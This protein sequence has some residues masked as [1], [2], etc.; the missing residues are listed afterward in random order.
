MP[1]PV[2]RHGNAA[3]LINSS[4]LL[5]ATYSDVYVGKEREKSASEMIIIY[6]FFPFTYIFQLTIFF[7]IKL[8]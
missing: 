8:D 7:T 4:L 1:R 5:I 2:S 3:M 6:Y